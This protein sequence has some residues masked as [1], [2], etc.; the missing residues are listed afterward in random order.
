[1]NAF[2]KRTVLAVMLLFIVCGIA[3]FYSPHRHFVGTLTICQGF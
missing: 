2:L 1:M 3:W